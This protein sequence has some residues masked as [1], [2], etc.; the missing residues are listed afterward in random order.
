MPKTYN[1]I[2]FSVRNK[3]R[4][5]ALRPLASGPYTSC[6]SRRK[7]NGQLMRDMYLYIA[8]GEER[9]HSMIER[10]LQGEAACVY[11]RLMGV[12]RFADDGNT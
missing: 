4:K 10:R 11:L 7:N 2:Y 1:D 6:R 9:T 8:R 3:L 12:L 5:A